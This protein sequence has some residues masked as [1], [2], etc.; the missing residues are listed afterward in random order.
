MISDADRQLVKITGVSSGIAFG[1]VGGMLR[2]RVVTFTVGDRG[3]FSLAFLL[4]DYTP[5]KVWDAIG[6]EIATLR[7][8][9]A[10]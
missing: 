3:P 4:V 7:G 5:A 10:L 9:G 2:T 8:I 1:G 6:G